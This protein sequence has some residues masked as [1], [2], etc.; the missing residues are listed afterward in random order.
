M[1]ERNGKPSNLSVWVL[2]AMLTINIVLMGF[3][4][5]S[6]NERNART[7]ALLDRLADDSQR[8][9]TQANTQAVQLAEVRVQIAEISNKLTKLL[10]P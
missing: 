2:G 7:E 5:Q 9:Q 1:T 10:G 6:L 3:V 4:W 8:V